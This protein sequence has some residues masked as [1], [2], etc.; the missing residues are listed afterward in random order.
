MAGDKIPR[1]VPS[2][3]GDAESVSIPADS[4]GRLQ[5]ADWI[6][7]PKNPM[8]SRVAV[9]RIWN[10][11]DRPRAGGE[12][13]QFGTTGGEPSHP[14]VVGSSGQA[15]SVALEHEESRSP[16]RAKCDLSAILE[17]RRSQAGRRSGECLPLANEP[18]SSRSRIDT[19]CRVGGL[20]M[21]DRRPSASQFRRSQRLRTGLIEEP[22]RFPSRCIVGTELRLRPSSTVVRFISAA[23]AMRSPRSSPC[24]TFRTRLRFRAARDHQCAGPVVIHDEQRVDCQASL[25]PSRPHNQSLPGKAGDNMQ[26]RLE[27][28]YRSTVGRSPTKQEA[29]AAENLISQLGTNSETAWSSLLEAYSPRPSSVTWIDDLPS[30]T[31]WFTVRPYMAI[32][33]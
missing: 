9:N 3:F 30:C 17:A 28:A 4:S 19:R 29:A 5:L 6:V 27:S 13:R 20:G 31:A 1:G 7:D 18:A 32:R 33:W 26:Q 23:R 25:G 22:R 15:I 12:C 8:T 24:S 10:W 2:L 21:L 16:N 14:D 11:F